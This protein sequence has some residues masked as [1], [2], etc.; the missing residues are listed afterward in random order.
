[1]LALVNAGYTKE[2]TDDFEPDQ[3]T[4]VRILLDAGYTKEDVDV[5]EW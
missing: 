3:I 5:L 2:E 4:A 1:M